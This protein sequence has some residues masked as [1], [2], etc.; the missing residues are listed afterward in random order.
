MAAVHCSQRCGFI[1]P[2]RPQGD[3]GEKTGALPGMM[4][5]RISDSC[6][7]RMPRESKGQQI[8]N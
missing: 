8:R 3:G 5:Q 6:G 7:G 2:Q 1:S 4:L